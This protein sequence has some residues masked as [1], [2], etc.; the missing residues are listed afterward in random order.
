MPNYGEKAK[1]KPIINIKDCF[2]H[3]NNNFLKN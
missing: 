3:I 2:G 1:Y